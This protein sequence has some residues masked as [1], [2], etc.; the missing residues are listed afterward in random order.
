MQ[1]RK[2]TVNRMSIAKMSTIHNSYRYFTVSVDGYEDRCMKGVIYQAG[3][4]P[5]FLFHNFLEMALHMNCIFDEMSCPKQTMDVRL[6]SGTRVPSPPIQRCGE[7]RDGK[8]ATFQ[9]Y[10]KY[11]YNASWQGEIAWLEGEQREDFSSFLQMLRIINTILGDSPNR[12][13]GGEI[14][15]ICQIA[16]DSFE[17]GLIEGSVQNAVLNHIRAF[18]GIVDLADAM[19]NLLEIGITG[20]DLVSVSDRERP[21]RKK[22]ITDETWKTYKKGGKKATFLIKILFRE[23]STWQGIIYWRENGE[24]QQFRSFLE[25]MFLMASAVAGADCGSEYEDRYYTDFGDRTLMQG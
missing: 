7:Y 20:S 11:R 19:G 14:T 17:E 23:H 12:T 21:G 15:D 2:G 8:L 3:Q 16:V 1:I 6:F 18:R 4:V 13:D 22:I 24:K 5:G 10:V 9:I 25:M